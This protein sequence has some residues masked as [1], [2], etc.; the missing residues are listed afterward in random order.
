[1]KFLSTIFWALGG[2]FTWIAVGVTAVGVAGSVMANKAGKQSAPGQ[3]PTVDPQ[4][5]QINTIQ[6]NQAA[7][8]Q[9]EQLA[10][11]TNTYNQSQALQMMNS[12]MPGYSKLAATLTGQA[13]GLASNPYSVPADVQANLQRQAAEMGVSTGR[14]GQAGQFSLL[15][16]LGVN[17]LQYGQTQLGE[18]SSLTGLLASIAPKTN[19]M[20]P[21]SMMLT[22]GQDIAVAQGNQQA[23]QAAMNATTAAANAN[24]TANAGMWGNITGSIIGGMTGMGGGIN[25]S[26]PTYN[27][28]ASGTA[29]GIGGMGGGLNGM[30]GSAAGSGMSMGAGGAGAF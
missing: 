11:D 27:P 28:S 16:D 2:W 18:A 29:M 9:A 13:Q 12:A 30:T 19:P 25:T 23:T 3:A 4:S 21:V 1:M 10:S 8:P 14:I 20:S 7:L 6:G 24:A 15:R 5:E 22:P 26:Q 17:E